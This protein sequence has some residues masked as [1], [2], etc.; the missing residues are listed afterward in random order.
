MATVDDLTQGIVSVLAG[1]LFPGTTFLNGSVAN[2]AAPWTGAPGAQ[3]LTIPT[4][5]YRG[6]PGIYDL[7]QDISAGVAQVCV[8]SVPGMSRNTSRFQPYYTTVSANVPTLAVAWNSESATFGG[9][10]AA[11]QA[12]G[13]TVNRV[14]YAYRTTANDTPATV[15]AAFAKQIPGAQAAGAVL[16]IFEITAA[17]VVCDQQGL[18]HTGTQQQM[19]QIAVLT[20][21][22]DG[23][24]AALVRA[25]VSSKVDGLKTML[26]PDGTVTRFIGLPD[27]S[28]AHVRF[29][30]SL[31]DDTPRNDDI[32]RRW[33]Y[34]L[35]EFDETVPVLQ[36]TAITANTLMATGAD[37]LV[38]LG[39]A[40]NVQNV[41]TDGAGNVLADSSGK[42]LGSF[43]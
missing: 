3:A 39:P 11:K 27:G 17:A 2:V 9:T 18:L 34:F 35:C 38:W 22:A 21:Y 10:C 28:S 6:A 23:E 43:S 14:C 33:L 37:S 19:V 30:H 20:P 5:L 25:A 4:R 12:V 36:P 42:M 15:A 41:L 31:D 29:H 26:R 40:P 16:S 8:T 24:S 7:D 1:L 32:W 13:L